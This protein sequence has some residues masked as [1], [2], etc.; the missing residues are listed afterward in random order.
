M[1]AA[2]V[3][4]EVVETLLGSAEMAQQGNVVSR[5]LSLCV[6]VD[7]NLCVEGREKRQALLTDMPA[8]GAF[9]ERNAGSP[10]ASV[11]LP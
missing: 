3:L 2:Q 1:S 10:R 4:P 5:P 9:G 8:E 7:I 6:F 11:V